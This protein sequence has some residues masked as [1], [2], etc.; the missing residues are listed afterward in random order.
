MSE[1]EL[2]KLCDE[3]AEAIK[4]GRCKPDGFLLEAIEIIEKEEE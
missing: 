1:E 4:E 2:D 3:A